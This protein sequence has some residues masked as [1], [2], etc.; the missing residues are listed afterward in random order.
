[1]DDFDIDACDSL[2]AEFGIIEAKPVELARDECDC[3]GIV[4]K[5]QVIGEFYMCDNCSTMKNA[6]IEQPGSVAKGPNTYQIG[7]RMYTCYGVTTRDRNDKIA[8]LINYFKNLITCNNHYVDPELLRDTCSVMFD[9]TS[10]NI[11]KKD[12]R[13]ALFAILLFYTSI[14]Q[15]RIMTFNEIKTLLK[16][17]KFKFSKG[18]KIM[19]NALLCGI[20]EPERIAVGVKVYDQLIAKYLHTYDPEFYLDDGN[21][22]KRNINNGSN[23]KFCMTMIEIVLN[24]NIAFNSVIQSKCIAIVYYL[25]LSRYKYCDEVKQRH[26]FSS[27]VG[28]GENTYIRVYNTLISPDAQRK[29][30]ESGKFI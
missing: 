27:I 6:Y 9:I 24:N 16:N 4:K 17:K 7:S 19:S 10:R 20:I 12:N 18:T 11:K 2:L 1:M 3:D 26:Y 13:I 8:D 25:V 29:F 23:R 21:Q 15:G 14:K 22:S 28:V 5:M 30:R